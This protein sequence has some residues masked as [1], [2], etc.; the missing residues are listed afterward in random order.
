MSRRGLRTHQLT[1]RKTGDHMVLDA[2][3]NTVMLAAITAL[4][5]RAAGAVRI[6][7]ATATIADRTMQ[8]SL[9]PPHP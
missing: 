9:V 3:S 1:N 5:L 6:K 2:E 8:P 4:T 7:A